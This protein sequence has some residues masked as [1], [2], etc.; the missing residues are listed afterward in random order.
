MRGNKENTVMA[1]LRLLL[2]VVFI[3][4]ATVKGID[5]MG[6]TYRVQDYLLA[7]GW[8]SLLPYALYLSFLVILSEF[9]LG[10]AF[11]FHLFMKTASWAMFAMLAF[12]T[13][14]TLLDGLYNWVPDCGCFGDAV[15]LTNWETFYKN[16]ILISM[17][18]AVLL[19]WKKRGTVTRFTPQFLILVFI[20]SGFLLFIAHNLNHLPMVDFRDWKTGRDMKPEG[21]DKVKTYVVYQN[22]KTGEKKTFEFPHFPWKDT[23]W[24][25]RW[26]FV[27]QRI[28]DSQ[29]V[30][31]H[32]LI[33]EDSIGNDYTQQIIDNP[34]NQ[35]ILA[36]YDLQ[37]SN[38]EGIKKAL[39]LYRY[40]KKNGLSMVLLTASDYSQIIKMEQA[41]QTDLPAF[42]SDDIE[43]KAMIRSNPGLL[44][45]KNGVVIKKWHYH[46]FPSPEQLRHMMETATH[47]NKG[48]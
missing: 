41:W 13:V 23:A 47:K 17:N 39:Q 9:L 45:L 36:A 15:K 31:K 34:E 19:Y 8:E 2:G 30:R 46:D 5:P 1:I 29:L 20:G 25:A 7:Y 44:W 43:L 10:L 38:P 35:F 27:S 12:F 21:L 48:R 28:D 42:L 33:I 3:F 32:H 40:L 37:K 4:S 6:T 11:L 26:K 24:M 18:M 16:I 22:K 14:V